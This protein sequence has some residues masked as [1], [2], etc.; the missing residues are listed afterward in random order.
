MAI[1]FWAASELRRRWRALTSLAVIAG[2]TAGLALAALAGARRTSTAYVRFRDVTNAPDVLVFATQV[3]IFDQDYS[4]VQQ[5]P[6]VLA[7]GVFT[8]APVGIDEHLMETLAPGDDQLYRTVSRPLLLNGRLPDPSRADELLVN[9]TA[10]ARFHLSVGQSVALTSSTDLADFFT[11]KH[12]PVSGGPSLRAT[13]VGIGDSTIDQVFYPDKPS[14]SP[15]AGFLARFSE[16]PRAPNLV[17][18]LRPGTDVA[19][20]KLR[21]AEALGLPDIPVRDL[22]EDHKRI[23]HGTDLERTGLLFFAA[24]VIVAGLVLV[25]QALTRTVYGIAQPVGTLRALGF[26]NRD[27]VGGVALI[28]TIPAAA[29]ACVAVASAMLFSARF[30]VGLAG[31]LE[32][33][34]GFHADWVVL[35]PGAAVLAL[36]LLACAAVAAYRV[37]ATFGSPAAPSNT[38]GVL[39]WV[40]ATAPLP[41][42]VGVGLAL[43]RGRGDRAVPVRP[44]LAG[45]IAGVLGVVGAS[46]LVRG[47][48]D[49]VAQ[50]GRSGQVWD[51]T[52]YQTEEH[53]GPALVEEL[54]GDSQVGDIAQLGRV[55]LDVAGT[56]LPVYTLDVVRGS[57]S[58]A[59]LSGRAPTAGEIVVGPATAAALGKSLGDSVRVGGPDGRDMR[60]V[61]TALLPQ[62]PHTSF[63]QGVWATTSDVAS[64]GSREPEEVDPELVVTRGQGI[65][66]AA[67]VNGLQRRYGD[68]EPA[69]PP[70]DVLFL[71]NV[72]TLP[73]ALAA[74]L[75]LLGFAAL[76]H[77]L[78]IAVRRRRHD[79]AVLRALGF[80]PRQNAAVIAWQA[81]TVAVVGLSLGLPF[82]VVAGR[83]AWRWVADATPLIY[84]PPLAAAAAALAVPMALLTANVLAVFPAR[85]AARLR[86]AEVLRSE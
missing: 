9:R 44:A 30:P 61:G 81:T 34:R 33:D 10:A 6:E 26:T 75:A 79:F 8:L 14:F 63:D 57:I 60:I 62:T 84:V 1:R 41:L 78:V 39:R 27:L 73:R 40:R 70:Q 24:A 76:G 59:V 50:P 23:L 13:V 64:M 12:K 22:A 29:S 17:V 65:S 4:A 25:G 35:G 86:P 7:A 77:A 67:L 54:L 36:L 43:E 74:F 49:A 45:A 52:V 83:L 47:I 82:G 51:A 20:F 42:A 19:R 72:R 31:R 46:G 11:A 21:A 69:T 58:F 32:P 28:V 18:R 68:V 3:G 66:R 37:V 5:L 48:D 16:V 56:G 53:H 15:S 80:G 71:Q 38:A 85:Q 55:P 2:L